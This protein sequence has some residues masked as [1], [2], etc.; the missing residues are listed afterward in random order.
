MWEH[1]QAIMYR[2]C[3]CHASVTLTQT[4]NHSTTSNNRIHHI[5]KSLGQ[6]AVLFI[7][8][9]LFAAF[10]QDVA[11]RQCAVEPKTYG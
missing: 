11:D 1:G 5:A 2:M 3:C 9:R 7:C 8:Q 10:E 4:T 6:F